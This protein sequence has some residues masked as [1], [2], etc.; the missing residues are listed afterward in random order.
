MA[1]GVRTKIVCK[2]MSSDT[3]V[4]VSKGWKKWRKALKRKRRRAKSR[5][6]ESSRWKKS[7]AS[8]A[9]GEQWPLGFGPR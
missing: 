1:V 9:N 6:T 3:E 5:N 8:K 4:G 2:G 7:K